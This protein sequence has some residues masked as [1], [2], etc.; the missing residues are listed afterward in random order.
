M[1]I[2]KDAG[3]YIAGHRG[4]AGSAITGKFQAEGFRN[5]VVRTHDQLDLTRQAETEAFFKEARPEYVVMAAARVGGIMANN[6]YPAEF[7]YTN[8][9]IQTHLI[10]AA[11][12]TGVK[13]LLFLGSSCI[14]PRDCPQPMREDHLLTG[15]LE[16]TNEPYAVAK[17]AGI[18]MCQSYNRQYGTRYLAVMPTNLYGPGDNFDLETSHVLP[19][20]IRKFHE[21]KTSR[22]GQVTIWGS[23]SPRREFL[24]A[25]DLAAACYFI[26]G[27]PDETYA[28]LA[29]GAVTPLINIGAGRDITIREMALLVQETVGFQGTVRFDDAKPDG[30]FQKLLEV[31]RMAGLGWRAA[32]PLREGIARTYRWCLQA[33]VFQ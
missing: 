18:K 29:T 2:S 19:A 20:L 16:P 31:S 28:S 21:A 1:A 8:L 7:I 13:R 6:T 15:P 10:H 4:L 3:I 30:T 32:I 33:G 9:A 14:Y 5:L 22:Q 24:H 27:L 25:D 23:G 12:L 11:Y 26:L 17:I